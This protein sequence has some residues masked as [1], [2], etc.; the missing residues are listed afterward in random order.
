MDDK[1]KGNANTKISPSKM[2]KKMCV[3]RAFNAHDNGINGNE[4]F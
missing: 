1:S 2:D 3:S 4:N